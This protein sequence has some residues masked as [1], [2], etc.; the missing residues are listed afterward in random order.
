M[1]QKGGSRAT[2]P[3]SNRRYEAVPPQ[4]APSVPAALEKIATATQRVVTKRID[5]FLLENR[6]L[7]KDLAV[8]AGF[9]A[10]GTI[11]ALAAWFSGIAA[12]VLFLMPQWSLAAKL[13]A[14]TGINL[15]VGAVVVAMSL[16]PAPKLPSE[17]EEEIEAEHRTEQQQDEHPQAP[18]TV[19]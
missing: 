12:L 17:R 15:I 13:L 19:H 3:V 1:A 11:T 18:S 7:V 6:E 4:P 10:F 16:R 9:V 5:L 14:F 2:D 8:K